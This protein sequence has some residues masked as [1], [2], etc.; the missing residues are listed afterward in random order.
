MGW[1]SNVEDIDLLKLKDLSFDLAKK[2]NELG[3][4]PQ[5][6]LY[7]E[8]AGLFIAHE[9][10]SYFRCPFSG[11]YAN[12]AGTKIKSKIKFILRYLPRSITHLL[13][14]IELRSNVH[15]VKK[16]RN[17]NMEEK[18]PSKDLNVLLVDDAVDTGFSLNA[19]LEFLRNNGYVSDKMKTA[20]LTTTQKNPIFRPDITLFEQITFA[21]PWSYDSREYKEAWML[22]DKIKTLISKR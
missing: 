7:I 12:R 16:E 8:R 13:L 6:I 20:V 9:I 3:F 19:V 22:Y 14:Q 1:T 17:V 10:A 18:L 21:F 11:I 4:K 15:S 5:H 2:V